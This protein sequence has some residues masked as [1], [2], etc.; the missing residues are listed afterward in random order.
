MF[1]YLHIYI[2]I[3]YIYI[4]IYG[5]DNKEPACN[6]GD[7]DLIP[8]SGRSPEEEMANHASIFARRISWTQATVHCVTDSDMTE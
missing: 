8:W 3:I 6:A 2:D 1:L 7:L 4:H 5:S